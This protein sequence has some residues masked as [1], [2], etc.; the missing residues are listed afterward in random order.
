MSSSLA[1]CGG[2]DPCPNSKLQIHMS[3]PVPPQIS[4]PECVPNLST[5]NFMKHFETA[6][7]LAVK[8]HLSQSLERSHCSAKCSIRPGF[9]LEI[10][11]SKTS[12]TDQGSFVTCMNVLFCIVSSNCVCPLMPGTSRAGCAPKVWKKPTVSFHMV[13]HPPLFLDEREVFVMC[14]TKGDLGRRNS[15]P[16]LW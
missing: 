13:P 11:I 8:H 1:T 15:L 16:L 5:F 4:K 12:S 9:I 10:G 6:K 2:Y 14:P 7:K 3:S